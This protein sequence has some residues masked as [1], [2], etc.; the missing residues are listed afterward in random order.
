MAKLALTTRH[1]AEAAPKLTSGPRPSAGAGRGLM[2]WR[3]GSLLLRRSLLRACTAIF[4]AAS[5]GSTG[6]IRTALAAR[7]TRP[8][9]PWGRDG[10]LKW[11]AFY[12]QTADEAVLSG[13]DVV[14][15]DPTF[16]GDLARVA[17]GGTRLCAYLSLGE[18]RQAD[19]Y[20]EHLDP[21]CLLQPNPAWPGTWRVD[22]RQAA[23][24]RVVLHE[25]LPAI[26][27]HGFVGLMLDTLDTPPWLEQV[28]PVAHRGMRQA[29]IDLV[30]AIRASFPDMLIIVNRGY[31]ILPDILPVIDAV[32]A[33]SL[34]TTPD[35]AGGGFH[36]NSPGA[37]VAQLSPLAVVGSS[38]P[39]LPILSLDYWDPNDVAGVQEI[40]RRQRALGHLPYVTTPLLSEITPEPTGSKASR[41]SE[42]TF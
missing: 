13:Y 6:V 36:W 40:Y 3:Q 11:L 18:I 41:G 39:P 12:G 27:S 24:Q 42:S 23:W 30:R 26:V 33:E 32:L 9:A 21:A 29:S 8:V 37:V 22:V 16:Q 20:F 1:Q 38:T 10:R 19:P 17:A 35:P 34:L 15:L 4:A 14:V 25:M 2:A 5:A 28:D 31:A 7:A